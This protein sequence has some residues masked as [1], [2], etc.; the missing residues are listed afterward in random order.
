MD[1]DV[2][3]VE[4]AGRSSCPAPRPYV[5]TDEEPKACTMSIKSASISQSSSQK[6]GLDRWPRYRLMRICLIRCTPSRRFRAPSSANKATAVR[7]RDSSRCV[8]PCSVPDDSHPAVASCGCASIHKCWTWR[9]H[10]DLE[11]DTRSVRGIDAMSRPIANSS[12]CCTM[13]VRYSIGA[14]IMLNVC[15][16]QLLRTA[17]AAADSSCAE[18]LVSSCAPL[19]RT[20]MDTHPVDPHADRQTVLM[21]CRLLTQ[22]HLHTSAQKANDSCPYF[23]W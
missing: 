18:R 16:S 1:G 4:Q 7:Q 19:T 22:V 8:S 12:S 13:T 9:R 23:W 11:R 10:S 3:G 20:N 17:H 15:N 21:Y 2:H 14:V 6:P 5:H